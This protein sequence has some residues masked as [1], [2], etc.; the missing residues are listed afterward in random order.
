[1]PSKTTIYSMFEKIPKSE[2]AKSREGKTRS[3]NIFEAKPGKFPGG[4]YPL[5][6][7]QIDHTPLNV[8]VV[9]EEFRE[10]IK[11]P[12][13][14]VAIDVFSR[15]IF[16]YYIALEKPSYYSVSQCLTVAF[17][18]KD[19]YLR[20]LGVEGQWDIYG[21]PRLIHA[22]NAWEFRGN[23]LTRVCADHGIIL[24]W[25]PVKTPHYGGHIERLC[26][27]LNEKIKAIPGTTFSN[28]KERGHYDSEKEA[29]MTMEELEKWFA[30]MV[31][32]DYHCELHTGIGMPPQKKYESGILG[33]GS[34]PG[35]G[36][37][38]V[39]EDEEQLLISLLPLEERSV[40]KDGIWIEGIPYWSDVLKNWVNI[41]NKKSP[42]GKFT[43]K[44]NP[45]SMKIVYFYDPELKRYFAVPYRDIGKPDMTLWQLRDAKKYL[46]EQGIK[47]YD[48]VKIFEAREL[49]KKLVEV[50]SK[51]TK[52]ARRKKS[53]DK[54]HERK[55]QLDH[56]YMTNSGKETPGTKTTIKKAAE[57]SLD[58][59]YKDIKPFS[60]I[61]IFQKNEGKHR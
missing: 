47:D 17:L 29:V 53:A 8:I 44:I 45:K 34:K 20:S 38:S 60:G 37:P 7:I 18:P 9:D 40:R 14:T 23:E 21:K 32:N 10:S 12:Y 59:L 33:D 61:K 57:A 6:I 26:G 5:D 46:R 24:E 58:E 51:K 56:S 22:D 3:E 39:I 19:K 2:R 27:T 28:V 54:F 4:D 48:E 30:N 11:R 16:G 41:S 52:E 43:F 50:A 35:V 36:L 49:N 42:N 25:R 1:M 31:V 15:V 13:L 55:R